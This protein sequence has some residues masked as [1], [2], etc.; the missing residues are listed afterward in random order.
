MCW[1]N[2]DE[3]IYGPLLGLLTGTRWSERH[4]MADFYPEIAFICKDRINATFGCVIIRVKN[5]V[6]GEHRDKPDFLSDRLLDKLKE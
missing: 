2:M 5:Y 4:L 3:T 1:Y 6:L